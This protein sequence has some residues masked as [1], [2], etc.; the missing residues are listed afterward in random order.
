MF[1]HKDLGSGCQCTM[2][3]TNHTIALK[4]ET[5]STQQQP[6]HARQQSREE[7]REHIDK[8][9]EKNVIKPAQLE[10]AS[11]IVLVPK[12]DDKLSNCVDYRRLNG[13]P[14]ATYGWF[15]LQLRR[16]SSFH[17]IRCSMGILTS[18]PQ[19]WGQGIDDLYLWLRYVPLHW[20]VF[21]LTQR[22]WYVPA[23][24]AY[25]PICSPVKVVLRLYLWRCYLF[26]K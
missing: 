12:T 13:L 9:L 8:Q 4:D 3:A 1:K 14:A 20:N 18:A 21:W 11:P 23:F 7:L 6:Y 26:K 10:L 2:K 22:T 25:Y 17:R 5:L 15:Y 16:S 19:R 24:V